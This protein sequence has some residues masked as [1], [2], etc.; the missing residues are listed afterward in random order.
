MY[1]AT[2][3]ILTCIGRT[4]RIGHRGV[5][6]SL[7]TERDEP[8]ASVLTRT[9]LETNQEIPNFLEMYKPEIVPGRGIQFET[10]SDFD[11]NE[12]RT[13]E[14]EHEGNE[15]GGGNEEPAAT[16]GNWGG[17]AE[18]PT[19]PVETSNGWGQNSHAVAAPV[20][21]QGYGTAPPVANSG[22][23]SQSRAAPLAENSTWGSASRAPGG[24][25]SEPVQNVAWGSAP[26]TENGPPTR[27]AN[28]VHGA[29]P[30]APT[31]ASA[32]PVAW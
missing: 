30:S 29:A 21:T 27:T 1:R 24:L 22:W 23:A 3:N 17:P 4:G 11:P 6:T 25:P 16:N 5:A 19:V 18:A 13:R 12:M 10:E 14:E 28:S 15:V 31:L 9:L 32:A 26:L 2:E 7:F 20:T 8:I